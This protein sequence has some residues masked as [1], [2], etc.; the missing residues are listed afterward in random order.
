MAIGPPSVSLVF[1][2]SFSKNSYSVCGAHT[3]V[4]SICAI[5]CALIH[6]SKLTTQQKKAKAAGWQAKFEMKEESLVS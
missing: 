3:H 1:S 5:I 2:Y 6:L 4:V